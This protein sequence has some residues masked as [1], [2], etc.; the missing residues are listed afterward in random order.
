MARRKCQSFSSRSRSPSSIDRSQ[1]LLSPIYTISTKLVYHITQQSLVRGS[2]CQQQH[3]GTNLHPHDRLLGHAWDYAPPD[4]LATHS[5]NMPP[6]FASLQPVPDMI[7]YPYL[8]VC[9]MAKLT[10][11]TPL[12][13]MLALKTQNQSKWKRCWKG[14]TVRM[15]F[16]QILG[17]QI[18]MALAN[19]EMNGSDH[20]LE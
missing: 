15:R 19:A 4:I 18:I 10:A 3:Y 2:A 7:P 17:V 14:A 20:C 5:P 8:V 9:R 6:T 1:P 13:Q 16:R 11:M 12:G